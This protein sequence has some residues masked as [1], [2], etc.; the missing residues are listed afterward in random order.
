MTGPPRQPERLLLYTA[1]VQNIVGVM[2]HML[3]F[4]CIANTHIFAKKTHVVPNVAH[5]KD[6]QSASL[7]RH[8]ISCKRLRVYSQ[9]DKPMLYEQA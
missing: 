8:T 3:S 7:A 4:Q 6:T 1:L 2:R 5:L 9:N